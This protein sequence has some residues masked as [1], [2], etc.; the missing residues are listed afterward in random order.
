L[1]ART[2]STV[3]LRSRTLDI[4]LQSSHKVGRSASVPAQMAATR[5]HAPTPVDG[6]SW[7]S[8]CSIASSQLVDSRA[9]SSRKIASR[10][11]K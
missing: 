8:S 7:S 5:S 2:V 9:S 1:N 4:T 10:L 11:S 3:T 6:L